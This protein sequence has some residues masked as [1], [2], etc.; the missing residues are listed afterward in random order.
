MSVKDELVSQYGG[1]WQGYV[2]AVGDSIC[3]LGCGA[4]ISEGESCH[5][6]T[7]DRGECVTL[8]CNECYDGADH[9]DG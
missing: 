1:H 6:L 5:V 2:Q 7:D 3:G 4:T 8:L 9:D